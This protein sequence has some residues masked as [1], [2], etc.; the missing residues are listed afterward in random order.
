MRGGIARTNLNGSLDP[1]LD[2]GTGAVAMGIVH[3]VARQN[4]GRIL[5]AGLFNGYNNASRNGIVRANNDGSLDSSFNPGT[6]FGQTGNVGVIA[7]QPDGKV[8]LGGGFSNYNGVSRANLARVNS[9]GILDTSFDSGAN[10]PVQSLAI[11]P[12]GKILIGGFFTT[13]F[14]VS[15]NGIARLN[16]DGTL[17]LSFNPGSGLPNALVNAIAIQSDG[18]ILI[19]GSFSSYNGINRQSL[20]RVNNDGS[21]DAAFN[22]ATI[23]QPLYAIAIQ[24]D[25]KILLGGFQTIIYSNG[26]GRNSIARLNIDGSLDTSF[27]PGSGTFD[28]VAEEAPEVFALAVQSDGRI[29]IGGLFTLY[30][31][32]TRNGIARIN[33]D[34]SLDTSFDPG[35]GASWV[36][37][38]ALQPDGKILLGGPFRDYN[39]VN[40]RGIAR[41]IGSTPT[42]PPTIQFSAPAY[43]ISEVGG[44]V[45]ATV[46]RSGGD[47]S[48]SAKI[49][50]A[51]SDTSGASAC[52]GMTGAA[53]ARCDYLITLGQLH[54]AA[55]ETSKTISIP[56]IDDSYLEGSETF[57]VTLTNPSGAT[58]GTTST[59]TITITDNDSATG[60]NPIDQASMFVRQHYLDFFESRARLQRS[61]LLDQ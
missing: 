23:S 27:D 39:R 1:S 54:F 2:P 60:V 41:L 61:Q 51:T 49:N 16:S 34:G 48:S 45:D 22:P 35:T 52:S 8:L 17:D 36:Q 20:V 3:V 29:V 28:P 40:R 10:A 18:R 30:N 7:I 56:I 31:G 57:T 32:V 38:L 25:G 55:S 24:S 19:A 44:H 4:D 43:S 46:T 14:G 6:G 33:S 13:Y 42:T 9:D 21:L 12:D 59:T 53:S 50:Y 11:Q 37:T 47:L 58:L 15:R 5:L 26:V